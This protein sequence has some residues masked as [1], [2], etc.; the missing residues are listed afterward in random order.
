MIYINVIIYLYIL[1]CKIVLIYI[2]FVWLYTILCIR[3]LTD[4][5]F[6]LKSLVEKLKATNWLHS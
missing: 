3:S 2:R 1:I 6:S 4:I 5:K